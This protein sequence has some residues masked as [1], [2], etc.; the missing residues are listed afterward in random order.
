M[1]FLFLAL[2]FGLILDFLVE[3]V[4]ADGVDD[5]VEEG[6]ALNKW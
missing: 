1:F 5:K 6:E 2:L 3:E 4:S